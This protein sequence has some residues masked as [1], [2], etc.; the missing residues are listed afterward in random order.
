LGIS[1]SAVMAT[2]D[3]IR[4]CVTD[5]GQL[6]KILGV[7]VGVS[8][9]KCYLADTW[10]HL[11]QALTMGADPDALPLCAINRG[12]VEYGW[13]SGPAHALSSTTTRALAEALGQL[14]S[15]PSLEARASAVG[16]RLS[17]LQTEIGRLHDFA[18]KAAREGKGLIFCR[19]EDW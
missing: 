5:S 6:E 3:Q 9:R 8:D 17:S 16:L 1:V 13:N 12:E 7:I 14:L 19:Y 2:D 4:E 11:H 18:S 15:G 10:R